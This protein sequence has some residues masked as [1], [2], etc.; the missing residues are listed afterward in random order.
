MENK[1]WCSH[2]EATGVPL[3]KNTKN[4]YGKQYYL[5]RT[6]SYEK[7]KKYSKDNPEKIRQINHRYES[8]N[9]EKTSAWKK[10]FRAN[11][12]KSPCV[13]CGSNNSVKHHDNYKEPLNI[14]WLC[15]A[16]HKELHSGLIFV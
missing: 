4:A 6:C 16:H 11:I 15:R 7:F 5:C 8:N 10:A 9:R 1:S 2:C 3:I 12:D 14:V 13:V